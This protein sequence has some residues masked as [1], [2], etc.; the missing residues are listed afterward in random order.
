MEPTVRN[1]EDRSR[2]ELLV[3][4]ATVGFAD[5]RTDGDRVVLPHT[6]IDPSM[7]GRGLGDVLVGAVLDDVRAQGRTVVPTCWFVAEFIERNAD[8]GDLLAGDT[9]STVTPHP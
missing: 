9:T 4:G 1:A 7:R 3:D 6:V 5:Y 2:Y 8:Y